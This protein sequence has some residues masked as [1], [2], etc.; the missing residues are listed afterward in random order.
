MKYNYT[1]GLLLALAIGTLVFF[2]GVK[3]CESYPF[4]AEWFGGECW[5]SPIEEDETRSQEEL[6]L[7]MKSQAQKDLSLVAADARNDEIVKAAIYALANS[8]TEEAADQLKEMARTHDSIEIRKTAL[9]ALAQCA[10]AEKLASFYK[11]IALSDNV[12]E[13]RKAAIYAL[14]QSGEESV[15]DVFV[16]LATSNQPIEIRK[17]AVYALNNFD[18]EPAHKALHKILTTVAHTL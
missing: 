13:L 12:L 8:G 17:A 4:L 10:S 14:G 3:A 18:A 16:E 7:V 2:S 11:E 9:Y 5:L 6:V 15:I 1:S